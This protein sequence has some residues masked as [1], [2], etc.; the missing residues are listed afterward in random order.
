MRILADENVPRP[1]VA[2]L[3]DTGQEQLMSFLFS[4]KTKMTSRNMKISERQRVA[5]QRFGQRFSACRQVWTKGRHHSISR[6]PAMGPLS[7]FVAGSSSWS[8]RPPAF[9]RQ[10]ARSHISFGSVLLCPPFRGL[11]GP[12]R[13]CGLVR[14]RRPEQLLA[15]FHSSEGDILRTIIWHSIALALLVGAIVWVYAHVFKGVVVMPI[16][17]S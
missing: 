2:W 4:T 17:P 5:R 11:G 3:R 7:G 15:S 1:N 10:V 16:V 13:G 9:A 6:Q 14:S 8:S 12:L